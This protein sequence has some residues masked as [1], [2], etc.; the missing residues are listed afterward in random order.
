M[1]REPRPGRISLGRSFQ[2]FAGGDN[3]AAAL[4]RQG[5]CNN[6]EK[7]LW[8]YVQQ[9]CADGPAGRC[10]CSTGRGGRKVAPAANVS[11]AVK[12]H[13]LQSVQVRIRMQKDTKCSHKY[14]TNNTTTISQVCSSYQTQPHLRLIVTSRTFGE[15]LWWEKERSRY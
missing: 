11:R 7:H 15:Y 9:L 10:P 6:H 8:R 1:V 5:E 4:H 12:V 2:C 13:V 14:T 3:L